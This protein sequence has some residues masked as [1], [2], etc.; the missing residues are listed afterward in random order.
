M[1]ADVDAAAQA[2][3]TKT[4]AAAADRDGDDAEAEAENE[5]SV[6][7]DAHHPERLPYTI[8]AVLDFPRRMLN[9]PEPGVKRV[10]SYRGEWV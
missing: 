4:A 2:P 8:H 6:H 7:E 1:K 3:A 9:P 10:R 5:F